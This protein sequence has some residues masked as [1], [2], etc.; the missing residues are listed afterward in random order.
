MKVRTSSSNFGSCC[1]ILSLSYHSAVLVLLIHLE[2]CTCKR[3]YLIKSNFREEIISLF[4]TKRL[5]LVRMRRCDAFK[6]PHATEK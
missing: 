3:Q 6:K 4:N 1:T 5:T 2:I